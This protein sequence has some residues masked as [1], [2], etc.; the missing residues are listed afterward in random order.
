M[1][2]LVFRNTPWTIDPKFPGVVTIK[3][4]WPLWR[5]QMW[6][7]ALASEGFNSPPVLWRPS[8][9]PLDQLVVWE[10]NNTG[11]QASQPL[12]Q[13]DWVTRDSAVYLAGLFGAIVTEQPFEGSVVSGP[14]APVQYVLNFSESF[15]SQ[16]VAFKIHAGTLAYYF[17]PAGQEPA[18][19]TLENPDL[20]MVEC[21]AV[22]GAAR[23][24]AL[25]AVRV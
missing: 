12:N 6:L 23:A 16:P 4:S 20:A 14:G 8:Y 22:I 2:D 9:L 25:R 19:A 13:Q 18:A 1:A 7:A 24:D 21:H 15:N 10:A 17:Q 3:D 11:G 5:K